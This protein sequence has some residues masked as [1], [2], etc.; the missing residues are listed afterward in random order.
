MEKAPHELGCSSGKLQ[1]VR[2]KGNK[3]RNFSSTSLQ[4]E[5]QT[6][7]RSSETHICGSIKMS[8]HNLG[9]Y[10]PSQHKKGLVTGFAESRNGGTK[11]ISSPKMNK[12]DKQ[13]A[14]IKTDPIIAQETS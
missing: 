9:L 8:I 5:K 10:Y 13:K 4:T 7:T 2:K 12:L 6:A 1:L 3:T 14:H 11:F